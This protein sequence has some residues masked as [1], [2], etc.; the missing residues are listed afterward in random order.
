MYKVKEV[1]PMYYTNDLV[2]TMEWFK[3]I[4]GWDSTIDE[5]DENEVATFGCVVQQD[6]LPFK[7]IYLSKGEPQEL[8]LASIHVEDIYSLYGHINQCNYEKVSELVET[9]WGSL[10]F[11]LTTLDGYKL[12]IYEM[13]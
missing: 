7:G 1:N 5:Y 13:K 8:T 3:L 11:T 9:N 10:S 4:L 6:E 12:Y 2:K